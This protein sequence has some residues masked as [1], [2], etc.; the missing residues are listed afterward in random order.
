MALKK[1][2]QYRGRGEQ[3]INVF[4]ESCLNIPLEIYMLTDDELEDES[5]EEF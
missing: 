3:G 2:W 1:G 4:F 5:D